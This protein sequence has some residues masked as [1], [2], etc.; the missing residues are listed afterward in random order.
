M[1]SRRLMSQGGNKQNKFGS[2]DLSS[3]GNTQ[4]PTSTY[5]NKDYTVS[6]AGNVIIPQLFT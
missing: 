5:H 2:F 6:G 4:T 3:L 1:L